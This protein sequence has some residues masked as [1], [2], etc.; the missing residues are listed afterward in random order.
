MCVY[1]LVPNAAEPYLTIAGIYEDQNDHDKA[2]EM[3]FFAAHCQR[4]KDLWLR[5][6]SECQQRQTND[7][8][9]TCYNNSKNYFSSRLRICRCRAA[10][11]RK[12]RL[13]L[14]QWQ[15]VSS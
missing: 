7:L 11:I 9:T 13:L 1:F 2:F 14:S 12:T 10:V 15:M 6:L 3:N 5:M 4:S 8:I